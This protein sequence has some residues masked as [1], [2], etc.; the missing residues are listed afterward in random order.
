MRHTSSGDS[1]SIIIISWPISVVCF[2]VRNH[3]IL[4]IIIL[5]IWSFS[6]V[7]FSLVLTASRSR[8]DKSRLYLTNTTKGGNVGCCHADVFGILISILLQ[9]LPFLVL[10]MLLIFKY[11]VLSY[12]NMFFT[13]KNTLVITL[14]VYRFVVLFLKR[15]EPEKEI[16]IETINGDIPQIPESSTFRRTS[17][18]RRKLLE[19][20]VNESFE[21][22]KS[23]PSSREYEVKPERHKWG[24]VYHFELIQIWCT[25]NSFY[26]RW[27]NFRAVHG[28]K[29]AQKCH[30]GFFAKIEMC[31]NN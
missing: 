9:D 25:V 27:F 21:P 10:R 7:Q 12:T 22:S 16:S 3:K 28:L 23:R 17:E 2:Q 30:Y 18:V 4:C 19:Y 13:S 11:N 29:G 8:K 14:L 31:E 24:H 15:N 26:L 1:Q 5:G 6:L 20:Y